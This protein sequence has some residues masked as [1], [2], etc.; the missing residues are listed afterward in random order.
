MTTKMNLRSRHQMQISK[1]YVC[2]QHQMTSS[3]DSIKWKHQITTF[4]IAIWSYS[5]LLQ[6]GILIRRGLMFSSYCSLSSSRKVFIWCINLE[7]H[8]VAV[9][10]GYI[11]NFRICCR[12]SHLIISYGEAPYTVPKGVDNFQ[13]YREM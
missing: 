2:W 9:M 5:P 6:F 13:Q 10:C 11:P 7:L 1:G 3:D 8:S 12:C 4:E